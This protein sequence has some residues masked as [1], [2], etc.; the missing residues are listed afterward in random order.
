MFAASKSPPLVGTNGNRPKGDIKGADTINFQLPTYLRQAGYQLST[1][2][3]PL[4]TNMLLTS[5]D[6]MILSCVK[7]QF[8][9]AEL[10]QIN[11]LIPQIKDWNYLIKTIIDRGIGPL[12]F[13]KLPLLSNRALI[14]EQVQTGLQQAYYKTLSRS[15]ILYEAFRKVAEA[16]TAEGIQVIVLKG[17][18]LSEQLYQDIGLR[19]FSDIDLL[20]KEEDGKKCL[21]ILKG[22]GFK[23]FDSSVT[24]FIGGQTEIVHHTPMVLNDISVEIHIRLHRKNKDYA[25]KTEDFIQHAQPVSINRIPV[26][27]LQLYDL[28]IHLC[29]HLDKHFTGGHVQF[30]SFNDITNILTIHAGEIEWTVFAKRCGENICEELVFKYLILINKYYNAPIP[31]TVVTKYSH[32]LKECDEELFLKYLHGFV[33]TSYHVGTHWQNMRQVKGFS[34]KAHYFSDL[35]FPPKKFIIQKYGLVGNGDSAVGSEQNFKLQTLNWKLKLW[36]LWYP[37][38]WWVGVKGII[39]LVCRK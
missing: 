30:T 27:A 24:E 29:V 28:L 26:H 34:S 35:I 1:T 12:L 33:A 36:W 10:E 13:K 14:P 16:L 15:M 17:I 19:Q 23:P 5:E 11:G 8:N 9:A 6:R 31:K 22:M 39:S 37:Y 20:V 4:L 7:I 25:I 18:Y 32:L 2:N 38:R 3:Y 21:T